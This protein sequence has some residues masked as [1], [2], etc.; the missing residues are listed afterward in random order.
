MDMASELAHLALAN[1]HLA[2]ADAAIDR[3]EKWIASHG[4]S[5]LLAPAEVLLITMRQ[6][7]EAMLDHRALIVRAISDEDASIAML[8]LGAARAET[9]GG[10]NR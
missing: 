9:R 5:R 6:A 8:A 10:R 7:R 3:Q 4:S 1:R 2:T